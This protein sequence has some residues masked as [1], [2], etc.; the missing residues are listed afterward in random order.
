MLWTKIYLKRSWIS[1]CF[2]RWVHSELHR[3]AL[4]MCT[5][6]DETEGTPFYLQERNKRVFLW[7]NDPQLGKIGNDAS[8]S[9]TNSS[10]VASSYSLLLEI[11]G[12]LPTNLELHSLRKEITVGKQ[13]KLDYLMLP[14]E[15]ASTSVI[16]CHFRRDLLTCQHVVRKESFLLLCTNK[17]IE[18]LVFSIFYSNVNWFRTRQS[19]H[20][21]QAVCG[22]SAWHFL[23]AS[24]LLNPVFTQI[25]WMSVQ[26][27]KPS[28]RTLG[29]QLLAD[30]EYSST[31]SPFL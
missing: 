31:N 19:S 22:I 29:Q 27:A 24:L 18:R 9:K 30:N 11:I 8:Y 26:Q 5:F 23:T 1:T 17:N 6:L 21:S 28:P 25:G 7:P 12:Q 15:L 16:L 3:C 4:C 14:Q 20:T 10:C 13:V 2:E